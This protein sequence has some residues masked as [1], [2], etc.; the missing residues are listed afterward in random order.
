[1]R[2]QTHQS[3]AARDIVAEDEE[4]GVKQRV[5]RRRRR[6]EELDAIWASVQCH[7]EVERLVHVMQDGE[8]VGRE[9][10]LIV[11]ICAQSETPERESVC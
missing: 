1:M 7:I 2:L 5:R 11:C 3:L 6:V 8:L 4:V 9:V 10:L